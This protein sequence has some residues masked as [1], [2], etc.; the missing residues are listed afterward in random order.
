MSNEKYTAIMVCETHWDR[1]WY[2]PYQEFR[3]RLVRLIDRLIDLLQR[4]P[5]FSSFMLDG[6]MIPIEDYLEIRPEQ[7]PVLRELVKSGKLFVGPWYVLAD[8]YLVS[9]ES[10]IRNL[11]LGL[12]M[13]ESLGG[14]TGTIM[15]EGYVPDAFGHIAQLPQILKGF[16]INSA[17][18]W[19]GVGDEGEELGTEFWWRAPDGSQVLTIFM[20]DG[21][22]NAANLGFPMRWGDPSAMEF[23]MDMAINQLKEA[24]TTLTP[25]VHTPFLLLMNGI[26]H[27]EA[28]PE[29]PQIIQRANEV[30]EDVEIIHGNLPDYIQRVR[31]AAPELPVFEGEFN[32]GRYALILQGVYSARM[33]LKQANE[34]VT[35]LLERYTEPIAVWASLLGGPYPRDF[36]WTAWR[37]LLKNHPHDDICG[38]SAD[39]IHR[40]NMYRFA[41]AEQIG[42]I[43]ARDGLRQITHHIDRS[44]QPGLPVVV[45]NP[46]AWE[47]SETID[48]VL[49]FDLDDPTAES[50]S[51]LNSRGEPVPDL[52]VLGR[53]ELFHLEVLK[54]SHKQG[55]RVA[56]PVRDIPPC[57]YR[58]YYAVPAQAAASS[59]GELQVLPQG[60]ENLFLRVEINGDGTLNVW[61]K[62]TGKA[63]QHLHYLEDTEDAGDEYDYSPCPE[64]QTLTSR[65]GQAEVELV[66]AGPAQ[67]TYRIS[68]TLNLPASL[69]EDRRRRSQEV[70]ECPF[71][72]LVT[73]RRG[74][75]HIEV[76]SEVD[77]QARDHRLRVCFL[78]EIQ[79]AHSYADSHFD[80][81][82]REI[83]LPAR[84]RWAQP[85]VPTRHQRYFVDLSDGTYGLAILNRGLPEYEIVSEKGPR[86]VMALTLLRCVGWLSRADLITRPED[87]GPSHKTPEAQCLG[88]HTF[89]YAILPHSGDWEQVYQEAYNYSAPLRLVRGD[90]HEGYDPT[91]WGLR[92]L[93]GPLHMK[94]IPRTGELPGELS[95]LSIQPAALVL[96][97]VKQSERSEGLIVR[98]YNITAD[99]VT[100][101]IKLFRPLAEAYRVNL[102]EERIESLQIEPD[103]GV[104]LPVKG[105]EV[106]TLE[107][108]CL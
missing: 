12:K 4:D 39:Q 29:V 31:A 98:F 54:G 13:A 43:L 96:S 67:V 66:H 58:V 73:L 97:A 101:T 78:T 42:T 91:E 103:G 25:Y 72:S 86:K 57:G 35:T 37:W 63:F 9:P 30:L 52:Q 34:Q 2:S 94:A 6:Q 53:E 76:V 75:R 18:F 36:L 10:L 60:M 95:F 20:I 64:S 15:K 55:V 88:R 107:L 84:N 106:V 83:D 8:E 108:R 5:E 104:S 11:M 50:F 47:R 61:D 77:N 70:V 38:C 79:T 49:P 1:A 33:Y 22:H 40:E 82:Q 87:A 24:I 65:G 59:T 71:T 68:I 89:E 16:G 81:I 62:E 102:N 21:Y 105:K 19:R 28:Q 45:F 92:E 48:A 23:D 100:A 3:I 85:P 7:Q 27:S 46:L 26:D 44:A 41:Q 90:E 93:K 80:V 51:L 17:V 32:R 74:S 14:T 69:S 99:P 56:F